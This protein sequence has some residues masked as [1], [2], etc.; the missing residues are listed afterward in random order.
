VGLCAAFALTRLL[1]GLLYNVTPTDPTVFVAVLSLLAGVAFLA[2][3][4]PA[5]RATRI[6]PI[7]ALRYE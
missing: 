3:Y 7:V 4:V 1:R 5:R 2:S 6:D